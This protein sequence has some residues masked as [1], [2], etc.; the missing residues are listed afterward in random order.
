MGYPGGRFAVRP[1]LFAETPAD[2][3]PPLFVRKSPFA[4][5]KPRTARLGA[6]LGRAQVTERRAH[7]RRGD[8]VT[9]TVGAHMA[10]TGRKP[11]FTARLRQWCWN[12]ELPLTLL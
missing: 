3:Q 8:T 5:V 6:G 7:S 12:A 10:N 1:H 4:S 9:G 2:S 11:C